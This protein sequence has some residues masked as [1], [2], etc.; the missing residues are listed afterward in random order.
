MLPVTSEPQFVSDLVER[1]V[2]NLSQLLHAE[3]LCKARGISVREALL[4]IGA[5][6]G[7]E[8]DAVVSQSDIERAEALARECGVP[9][10]ELTYVQV[11]PQIIELI[12]E[13][14]ARE[15]RVLPL[16]HSDGA[17][18]VAVADPRDRNLLNKLRFILNKEIHPFVA[19]LDQIEEA[20]NRYYGETEVD[21]V[22]SMLVEFTD[23]QIDFSETDGA[24]LPEQDVFE[25]D[26][27][28]PALVDDATSQV[29]ALEESAADL[30]SCEFNLTL[31]DTICSALIESESVDEMLLEEQ[32]D[33]EEE[34]EE[35]ASQD[36]VPLRGLAVGMPAAPAAAAAPG[37]AH[38][39]RAKAGPPLVQRHATVRYYYR[40]NP[41]RMYPLLVVISRKVVQE[42][43][44]KN[45][46]QKR[47]QNFEVKLDSLV[48]IEPVLPGCQC[49]P[50]KE[51]MTIGRGEVTARF[52]VVPHVLGSV[53]QARVVIRQNGQV[54]AEVPLELGVVKPGLTVLMGALSFVLPFGL[55]LMKQF[56]LDFESQAADNF[57]LYAQAG[58]WAVQSLAPESLTMAL[59]VLTGLVYL[60]LRPRQRD[61]FW[62]VSTEP[63]DGVAADERPARPQATASGQKADVVVEP[64]MANLLATA[65]SCYLRQEFG[66]ALSYYRAGLLLGRGGASHYHHAALCADHVGNQQVALDFLK[67]MEAR[68]EPRE[69]PAAIWFHMGCILTRLGRHADAVRCLNRAADAGYDDP[70]EYRD[71]PD[72]EALRWR[73]DFKRLIG[74]LKR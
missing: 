74:S 1:K 60:W 32:L 55:L 37:L 50:P 18:L 47:S 9:F 61:V 40:M 25:T 65:E 36:R 30:E 34:A 20:I 8:F 42:I 24:S 31:D 26:F 10:I 69:I 11:P 22:D 48:E 6:T 14:V 12:P 35:S 5:I 53:D 63:R 3:W 33:E 62:D 66:R 16:G 52:H 27:D 29:V 45:V 21:S 28:L 23:T 51:Q 39:L 38:R 57:A 43:E 59:L 71:D 44:K 49:Y 56:H 70:D 19:P 7:E 4:E 2:I 13:S 73:S 54:L 67:D 15:N 46:T 17:L 68:F 64:E 58:N 72:L 41:L